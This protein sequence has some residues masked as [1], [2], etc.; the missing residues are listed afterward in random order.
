MRRILSVAILLVISVSLFAQKDVT[1]FMGIPIDGFKPEM[2]QKLKEKGFVSSTNDKNIL[3]GEFNGTQVNIHVV[4]NNNKVC[5]IMLCDVH[6]MDETDI[7]IRFNRLCQQFK[8]N[9]NY[10]S[11]SDQTIADDED[12]AYELTVHDK[13]YEAI[14]YQKPLAVD[15]IEIANKLKE[16]IL[17]KYTQ[18]ELDNPTEEIQKDIYNMSLDYATEIILKK[19]VWFMIS[20]FAGRYYITMFYDNEYNRANGEDL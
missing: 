2:I 9:S 1:K 4:T 8:N 19:P 10:V 14:F 20:K 12:I 15:S 3:E 13:R 11:F 6:Q 7:R 17:S 16:S 18:Q 5:R